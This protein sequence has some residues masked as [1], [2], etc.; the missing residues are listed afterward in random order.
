[1]GGRDAGMA[2]AERWVVRVSKYHPLLLHHEL[3]EL[4]VWRRIGLA[5]FFR[6]GDIGYR[7]LTINAAITI[8]VS[9]PDHLVN[10]VV[11]ELLADRSHN[12]T[13]LGS[14]NETVVV[15]IEDLGAESV[16][17]VGASKLLSHEP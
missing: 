14:G 7:C 13:E 2:T 10:L 16:W 9:L 5:A 1:M 15:T 4:V 3:D 8:L 6:A 11:S 12:V 17:Q